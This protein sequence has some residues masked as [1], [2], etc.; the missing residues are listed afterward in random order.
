MEDALVLSC[1]DEH[2]FKR[3]LPTEHHVSKVTLWLYTWSPCTELTVRWRVLL[4]MTQTSMDPLYTSL[5]SVS[6]M[7]ALIWSS[8]LVIHCHE[9][10]K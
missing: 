7:E 5:V 3:Q 4:L 8:Q 6:Y 2:N 9:A 1:C 10:W